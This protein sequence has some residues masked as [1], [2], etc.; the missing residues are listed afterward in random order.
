MRHSVL[1]FDICRSLSKM[2]L[3]DETKNLLEPC[4]RSRLALLKTSSKAQIC[5]TS[6]KVENDKLATK[7]VKHRITSFSKSQ[8]PSATDSNNCVLRS[9]PSSNRMSTKT[10]K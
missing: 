5:K 10:L 7:T 4:T 3:F 9:F 8:Q 2:T 6:L 1:S